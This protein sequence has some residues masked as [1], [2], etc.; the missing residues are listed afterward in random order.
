MPR[1]KQE[2]EKRDYE[3]MA[4]I[5]GVSRGNNLR[6]PEPPTTADTTAQQYIAALE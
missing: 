2:A 3:S 5:R 6:T 4:A 1:I